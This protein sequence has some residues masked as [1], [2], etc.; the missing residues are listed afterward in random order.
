VES[1]DTVSSESVMQMATQIVVA[2][3]AHG[4][5]EAEQLPEMVSRVREALVHPAERGRAPES[6]AASSLPA[7]TSAEGDPAGEETPAAEEAVAAVAPAPLTPPMPV[8]QTIREDHLISL[9]DGRPYRSLKRHLQAR[10]G[11][12]PEQYRAKWGLPP[13]YPMVAPSFA[14]SGR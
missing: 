10:Y 9:E 8:D 6:G 4:S 13:D 14:R 11:M 12:T 2:Y 7:E 3:L 5:L 1:A